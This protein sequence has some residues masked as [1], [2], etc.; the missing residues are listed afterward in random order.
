MM[1]L[2]LAIGIFAV[3][4]SLVAGLFPAAIKEAEST[5]KDYEGPI[6]CEN[7]LAIVKA[8]VTNANLASYFTAQSN[9]EMVELAETGTVDI[10]ADDRIYKD[11]GTRKRGFTA[12]AHRWKID[13]NDY[14]LVIVAYDIASGTNNIRAEQLSVS[15]TIDKAAIQFEYAGTKTGLIGSP[16][17]DPA[18]GRYATIIGIDGDTIYLD[19][20]IGENT[21]DPFVIR[22]V[23]GLPTSTNFVDNNP[24]LGVLTTRTALR[25]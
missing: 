13:R 9:P 7:G 5:V 14:Q 3:G 15:A 1:E 24:V 6:I 20:S 22:E 10:G 21:D 18:S 8:R 12:L 4:M 11:N 16:A 2:M 23:V 17:I 19:H 25:D